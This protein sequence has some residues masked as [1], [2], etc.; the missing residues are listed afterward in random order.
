MNAIAPKAK[1]N[2]I[3]GSPKANRF[4]R[5]GRPTWRDVLTDEQ[6]SCIEAAHSGMMGKF[7]YEIR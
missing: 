1:F 6:V 2:A 4:F 3:E 5:N 7:G